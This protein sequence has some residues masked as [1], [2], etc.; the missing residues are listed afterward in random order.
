MLKRGEMYYR[1]KQKGLTLP[2]QL[3]HNNP[4][5][6]LYLEHRKEQEDKAAKAAKAS[7]AKKAKSPPKKTE[8][9]E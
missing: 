8:G 4:E 9:A 5:L 6:D 1:R 2:S 3:L 7:K